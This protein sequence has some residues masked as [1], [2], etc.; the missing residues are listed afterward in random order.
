MITALNKKGTAVVNFDGT[1]DSVT[2]TVLGKFNIEK[3]EGRGAY[4]SLKG[5]G[6]YTGKATPVFTVTFTVQPKH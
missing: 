1:V 4:A 2:Y 3:K 6:D 5:Q